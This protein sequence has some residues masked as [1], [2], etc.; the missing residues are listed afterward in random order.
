M[1]KETGKEGGG[2]FTGGKR[3]LLLALAVLGMVL[4]M[5]GNRIPT[6]LSSEKQSESEQDEVSAGDELSQYAKA[7]TREIEQLCASVEGAGTVHAVVSLDGG[8]TYLYAADR[9]QKSDASGGAQSS[10]S[11]ITVGSGSGESAVLLTKIPP[12]I[13]GIGIVCSGGDRATVRAEIISLLDAAYGVG[14]N[15]IYVTRGN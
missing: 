4:L 7:L 8:F 15:R 10:E 14:T 9:E 12:A 2:T 11:Y 5:F 6:W 13:A 3:Y 1:G